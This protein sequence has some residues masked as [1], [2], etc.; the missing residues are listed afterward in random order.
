MNFKI[1]KKKL[2]KIVM[3]I[4]IQAKLNRM[5]LIAKALTISGKIHVF[6]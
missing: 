5:F 2:G 1:I 3:R 6:I 4:M